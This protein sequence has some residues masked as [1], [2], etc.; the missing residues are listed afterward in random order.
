MTAK[1]APLANIPRLEAL[2]DEARLDAVVARSG[3]NFTYLTGIVYP[4]TLARHVDLTDS[5]RGVFAV[6]P[7][8]GEAVVVT[9]AIAAGLAARD[10]CIERIEVY[11]GYSEPPED[12]LCGVLRDLGLADARVGFED[13]YLSAR[14]AR[15]VGR[16]LPSLQMIDCTALMDRVRWIKTPGEIERLRRGADL[17]DE[18][19]LEVFPTIRDGESERAVHSRLIASCIRRGA[20]W[21]HG[22]LNS[23]S[24]TVPYAG[25]SSHPFRRGEAIRTDY[26]AYLDGYPGHQSRCAVMGPPSDQQRQEYRTIRDLYRAA[27]DRCRPGVTAGEVYA[28]V[29][30]SFAAAGIEYR[31][32]LAGHSVGAWWHQQAPIIAKGEPTPLE[33][34]MVI[35]MEPHVNHWHIQDMLLIRDDGPELLSTR[36]ATDEPFVVP[37]D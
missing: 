10:S 5:P 17:L 12:C 30:E 28:F 13:D 9:N 35:A 11:D 29:V 15:N 27:C 20:G 37:L 2:M 16:T 3:N 23:E 6:Y 21:A 22:I 1:A 14:V 36:F 8:H 32:M 18:A 31:S 33:A 7:R 24:N 26:V 25:E 34:G 4:G 19:Y